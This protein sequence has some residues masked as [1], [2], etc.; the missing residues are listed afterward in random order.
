M[1]LKKIIFSLII[2][3]MIIASVC[4]FWKNTLIV[5]F[6]LL[7]IAILK[8]KFFPI[9]KELLWFIIAAIVGSMAENIMI[10]SSAWY[11]TKPQIGNIPYWLPFLWGSSGTMLVTFYEGIIED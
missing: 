8:H 10:F 5:S 9:K 2:S 4:L 3:V 11:Y 7:L 1:N 6:S